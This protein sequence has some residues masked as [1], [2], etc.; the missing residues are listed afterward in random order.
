MFTELLNVCTI[1]IFGI[2]E[3]IKFVSLNDDSCQARPTFVNINSDETLFHPFAVSVNKCGGSCNFIDDP[4][5][6][7]CVPDKIKTC[8]N[9]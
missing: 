1:G 6:R 4:Y 5:T 2:F 3:P 7:A 9:I 8:K